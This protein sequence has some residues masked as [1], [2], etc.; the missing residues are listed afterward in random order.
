[1]KLRTGAFLALGLAL[2]ASP[3]YAQNVT[4]G[5][6]IGVNF[7]KVSTD[8]DQNLDGKTGLVIGGFVDAAVTPQFSVQPEFLFTMKGAKD[9]TESPEVSVDV[10]LIEIPVLAKFKFASKSQAKP[11][12]VA[13]PGF[14]FVV[15]AKA[16]QDGQPDFDFKDGIEKFD[17]SFIIGGGVDI[18]NFLVEAR[19]DLGLRDINKNTLEDLGTASF[20]DRT[21]SIL[22]GYGFGKTK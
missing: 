10:N 1:M 17:P 11:F 7:A 5:G 14:G 21:F 18:N 6:K 2:I 20:K 22:V 4:G 12:V 16:K 3:G 15:S 13:G 8:P 19:Y 9:K